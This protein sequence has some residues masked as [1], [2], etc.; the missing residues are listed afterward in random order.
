MRR[1]ALF[2]IPT[3]LTFF[4]SSAAPAEEWY[5]ALESSTI[6][7]APNVNRIVAS[8]AAHPLDLEELKSSLRAEIAAN[9]ANERHARP[10]AGY[11]ARSPE[12]V[13]SVRATQPLTPPSAGGP[14]SAID[15]VGA[16][17]MVPVPTFAP[18]TTSE[19][20]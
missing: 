19:G 10:I 15:M 8:P 4:I 5:E 17:S 9:V 3:F 1:S 14:I 16:G 2:F 12:A 7:Y 13:A 18:T 6:V 11:V 20:R